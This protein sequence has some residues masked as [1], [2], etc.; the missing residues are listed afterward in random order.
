[1][2]RRRSRVD[3]GA[4]AIQPRAHAREQPPEPCHHGCRLT[5]AHYPTCDGGRCKGCLPRPADVGNLCQWCFNELG[6]D[7]ATIGERLPWLDTLATTALDASAAPPDEIVTRAG[8]PAEGTVL[9]P[10]ALAADE[11]RSILV[12]YVRVVADERGLRDVDAHDPAAWL[13]PHLDW[14]AGQE[15]AHDLRAEL[16]HL[17]GAVS[18]FHGPGDV[19]P[20]RPLDEP[21]PRCDQIALWVT[22]PRWGGQ[23]ERVECTNPDCARVFS[24]GEWARFQ[25]TA[26]A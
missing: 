9:H 24:E 10:A 5:G 6:R 1:M 7:I 23:E 17:A 14:L 4:G 20:A 16:A 22:P 18:R 11:A 13:A 12:F 19:E 26:A 8:D 15:F 2:S 21:C 3:T 25:G